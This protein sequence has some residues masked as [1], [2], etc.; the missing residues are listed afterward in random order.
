M[1]HTHE[2]ALKKELDLFRR[3]IRCSAPVCP[4]GFVKF[5][6]VALRIEVNC[7]VDEAE[8]EAFSG[9]INDDVYSHIIGVYS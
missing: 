7:S 8:D 5:V 1:R 2:E 4:V 9:P 3:H 6:V